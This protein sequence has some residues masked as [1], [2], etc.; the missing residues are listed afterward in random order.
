MRLKDE[1]ALTAETLRMEFQFQTGA[2][3]SL[4]LAFIDTLSTTRFNSK[5]VRLK[6]IPKAE[7]LQEVTFQFQTGAIKRNARR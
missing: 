5:L 4:N 1:D 6:A 2:I 7:L 3:K